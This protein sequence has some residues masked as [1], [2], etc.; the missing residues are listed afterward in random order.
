MSFV[1]V[2]EKLFKAYNKVWDKNINIMPKGT[3]V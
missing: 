2:D 1:I 3:N